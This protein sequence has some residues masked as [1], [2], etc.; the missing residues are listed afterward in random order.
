M[1]THSWLNTKNNK[2]TIAIFWLVQFDLVHATQ[3]FTIC[4]MWLIYVSI[5]IRT[6][7]LFVF[8]LCVVHLCLFWSWNAVCA[9]HWRSD[10][11]ACFSLSLFNQVILWSTHST[12]I[13][14]QLWPFNIIISVSLCC[15]MF[16]GRNYRWWDNKKT[17]RLR[18][19]KNKAVC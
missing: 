1:I 4:D 7:S 5:E 14:N 18:G 3:R 10:R 6:E 11:D 16:A 2:T 13:P 17:K 8:F 19:N 15:A 9:S 12:I